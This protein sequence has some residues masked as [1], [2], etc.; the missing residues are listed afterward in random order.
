MSIVWA[1]VHFNPGYALTRNGKNLCRQ[2][3][4]WG[5]AGKR[6]K[7]S[8]PCENPL[9]KT[10]LSANKELPHYQG[11]WKKDS[12]HTTAQKNRDLDLP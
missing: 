9:D 12:P 11:H 3:R 4:Q 7:S 6:I 5:S 8:G 2:T 10:L 1:Q